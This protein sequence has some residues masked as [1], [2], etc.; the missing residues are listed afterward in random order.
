MA[1]AQ[2]FVFDAYGTLFD[3]HSVVAALEE[4]TPNAE[5]VSLLW[6]AKQLEYPWLR[7]LMGRYADFWALTDE[8]LRF[9]LKRYGIRMTP[10]QHTALLEAA[11]ASSGLAGKF[12][13]LVS[14]SHESTMT[15]LL[16]PGRER[17][18]MEGAASNLSSPLCPISIIPRPPPGTLAL[19]D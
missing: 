17:S 4:V 1:S 9:A 15:W 14:L 8:A 3:V 10:G 12:T 11:V 16:F 6:R 13:H 5:A 19:S 7:A 2:G 18:H